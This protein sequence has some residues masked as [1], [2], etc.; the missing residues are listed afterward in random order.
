MLWLAAHS[1]GSRAEESTFGPL[2]GRRG[3]PHEVRG[4]DTAGQGWSGARDRPRA[5]GE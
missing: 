3:S 4:I 2:G 5:Y 1:I